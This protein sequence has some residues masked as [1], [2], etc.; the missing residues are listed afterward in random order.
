M[1]RRHAGQDRN[2][3]EALTAETSMLPEL[4]SSGQNCKTIPILLDVM[5]FRPKQDQ[6]LASW[7]EKISGACVLIF[8]FVR[9]P[10]KPRAGKQWS[11]G[12]S[13]RQPMQISRKPTAR[14]GVPRINI[15][16]GATAEREREI[17]CGWAGRWPEGHNGDP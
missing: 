11:K 7:K 17:W 4:T 8:F 15:P 3:P 5:A 14:W 10:L 9:T 16:L 1:S 2:A 6:T 13:H 12:Q